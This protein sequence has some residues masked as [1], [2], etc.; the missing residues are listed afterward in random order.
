MKPKKSKKI[1]VIII[2]AVILVIAL[3]GV[4]YC[5][6]ATDI[7]KSNKELFFKYMG[8]VLNEENG[9]IEQPLKQYFEKQKNTPY[10]TQGTITTTVTK[11]G[12]QV[13][14]YKTL[15]DFNIS[16]SGQVDTANDQCMQEIHL[17]YS[18]NV[19][20]PLTYKK[21]KDKI[22]IQTEYVGSK[23]VTVE[24]EK[25]GDSSVEMLEG[26]ADSIEQAEALKQI[27]FTRKIS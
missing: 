15:N 16:F 3:V 4:A 5:Y 20:F 22:G 2:I 27:P 23:Y 13:Q 19:N 21:I 9:M 24:E 7:F 26:A 17:N 6:F 1:L 10:T 12:Q 14:T 25:L 8:Q 11:D 18:E